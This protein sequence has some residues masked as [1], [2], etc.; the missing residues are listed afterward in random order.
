[1]KVIALMLV[2]A[3]VMAQTLTTVADTIRAPVSGELFSGRVTIVAPEI[4]WNGTTYSRGTTSATLT[5]GVFSQTF[6]PNVGATPEG[7]SYRVTFQSRGGV[8]WSE[9]WQVPDSPSTP[10]KV[11]QVRRASNPDISTSVPLWRLGDA[12][13]SA[14]KVLCS[15]G[16]S[17][18]PCRIRQ[19]GEARTFD[20]AAVTSLTVSQAQ[21]GFS[22][23]NLA[24]KVFDATGKE[25]I[26]GALTI[27]PSTYAVTVEF[28]TAQSG[29]VVIQQSP[30]TSATFT[31]QTTVTITGAVHGLG[32]NVEGF[33]FDGDGKAIRPGGF[34]VNPTSYDAVFTF[35]A[36]QTGRC[37]VR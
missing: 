28:S 37:Y 1:M 17:W 5:N 27:N 23:A 22:T 19:S 20:L 16:V 29:R 8:T 10:L 30:S 21:H 11:H 18:Y 7:T 9:W 2:C 6:V 15:D 4:T 34:S 3:G 32:A 35:A 26:P 24:V 33:C 36:A 14:G 12:S 31:S 25:I 13:N